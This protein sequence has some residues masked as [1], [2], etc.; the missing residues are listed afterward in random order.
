MISFNP[1][2]WFAVIMNHW[3]QGISHIFLAAIASNLISI[4]TIMTLST[5]L[6]VADFGKYAL[7]TSILSFPQLV[8][9]AGFS[10]TI[11]NFYA[12]VQAL[13]KETKFNLNTSILFQILILISLISIAL[14]YRVS[15]SQYNFKSVLACFSFAVSSACLSFIDANNLARKNYH[16]FSYYSLYVAAGRLVAL[17]VFFRCSSTPYSIDTI[18]TIW[19]TIQFGWF[20]YFFGKLSKLDDFFFKLKWPSK[21]QFESFRKGEFLPYLFNF[22]IFSAFSWSQ[23]FSEKW[24]LNRYISRESVAIFTIY[25]QYGYFPFVVA[26]A[27]L[28][29]YATPLLNQNK[30]SDWEA[31]KILVTK[32][33]VFCILTLVAFLMSTPILAAKLGPLLIPI[34]SSRAY[35]NE[36]SIFPLFVVAGCFVFVNQALTVPLLMEKTIRKSAHSKAFTSVVA[37]SLYLIFAETY[38]ISGIIGSLLFSNLVSLGFCLLILNLEFRWIDRSILLKFINASRRLKYELNCFF[39]RRP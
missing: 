28:G 24:I 10:A 13:S 26:A 39:R 2:S 27:I 12:S 38:G 19:S 23:S 31:H 16:S 8:L 7:Y 21:S 9:W 1:R 5:H 33:V 20:A 25:F 11:S 32:Y 18:F 22:S 14:L 6:A 4:V 37:I 15:F 29:Q 30:Y 3:R 34:F 35:L 36:I 17:I